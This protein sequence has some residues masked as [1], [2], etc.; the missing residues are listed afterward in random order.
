MSQITDVILSAGNAASIQSITFSDE[1]GLDSGTIR[2]EFVGGVN[3]PQFEQFT[4]DIIT[5]DAGSAA[6]VPEPSTVLL[7][8]TGLVG[9]V[10]YGHR[11]RNAM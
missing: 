9:L 10:G 1:L 6:P 4:F 8:G 11:R 5:G 3:I 7:L 2:V